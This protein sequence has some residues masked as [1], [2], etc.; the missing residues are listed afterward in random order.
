VHLGEEQASEE[1]RQ[2]LH[3]QKEVFPAGDPALA[4]ER[5]AAAGRHA[6]DMGMMLQGLAQVCRTA[7]MPS[8]AP[9]CLGSAATVESV[10]AA[11]R[12]RMA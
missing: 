9:R 11:V 8:S 1:A 12:I 6:V 5:R 2:H 3:R 7:V 4:I 10:S